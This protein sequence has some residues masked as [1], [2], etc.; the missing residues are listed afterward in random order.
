MAPSFDVVGLL[1]RRIDVLASAAGAVLEGAPSSWRPTG[2][3]LADD[4]LALADPDV[5]EPFVRETA[6]LAARA[7]LPRSL[8]T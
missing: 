5:V 3:L 7:G 8:L 2:F 1:T 6:A 4:L